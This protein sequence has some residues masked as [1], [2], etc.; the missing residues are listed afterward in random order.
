MKTTD[1]LAPGGEQWLRTIS[2]S[3][4]AAILGVSRY[5]SPYR[6]WH[7]QKGLVP[8]EGPK[9]IFTA[10]HAFEPALAY[11]WR[12]ENPG[13]LL[14]PGEVRITRDDL[15]FP[16]VCTLDRRARRGGARRIVEFKTTRDLADWGDDFTDQAPADYLAQVQFQ[17][18]LTGFTKWPAHLMV[19]GPFFQWHTYEV[20][21]DPELCA[22]IEDRCRAWHASLALDVPPELDDTVAT[23]NCVR[24][25]HPEI[26]GTEVQLD[27]DLAVEYLEADAEAKAIDKRLRAAKTR[28]LDAMKNAKTAN[29]FDQKVADRRPGRGGA[30]SLYAN[31]KSLDSLKELAA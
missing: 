6:L 28:V 11:L 24:A 19:M 14:S 8:T 1:P 26:D 23:Y 4:V 29:C 20:E 25:L 30:V 12:N 15:G 21:Y 7:R 16:A 5:E 31:G 27:A 17:M 13:W 18:H 10:G 9:D 3:K 22:V 2:P